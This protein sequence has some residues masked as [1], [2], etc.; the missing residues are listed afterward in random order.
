MEIVSEGDEGDTVG[1]QIFNR[2]HQVLQAASK[3]IA[4]GTPRVLILPML[5]GAFR[6]P[7]LVPEV[8]L[9]AR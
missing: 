3:P 9:F 7:L 8:L 6:P 1:T 5:F 2:G 4:E